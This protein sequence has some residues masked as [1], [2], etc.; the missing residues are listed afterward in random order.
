MASLIW[1]ISCGRCQSLELRLIKL[2]ENIDF[3]ILVALRHLTGVGTSR[4]KE[5]VRC[6]H[7]RAGTLF[8]EKWRS[9][10]FNLHLNPHYYIF[11]LPLIPSPHWG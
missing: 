4:M 1:Y 5:S 10:K 9:P 11:V 2:I 3:A 8:V 6:K 7:F